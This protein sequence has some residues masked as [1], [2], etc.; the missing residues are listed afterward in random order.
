MIV[1]VGICLAVALTSLPGA[2]AVHFVLGLFMYST[3]LGAALFFCAM[4]LTA[5]F[6]ACFVSLAGPPRVKLTGFLVC[7]LAAGNL[8]NIVTFF[9]YQQR[10][11]L[12]LTLPFYHWLDGQNSFCSLLHNHT[13]K[14]ALAL[15]ADLLPG[16]GAPGG[17]DFGGVFLDHAP[18]WISVVLAFLLLAG[19]GLLM[20]GIPEVMRRYQSSGTVFLLYIIAGAMCLKTMVDGGPLTYRFAPSMLILSS[21]ALS[22]NRESLSAFWQGRG[23]A[24]SV[25]AC[26]PLMVLWVWVGGESWPS[27]IGPFM[28]LCALYTLLLLRLRPRR[29][30]FGKAATVG[31]LVYLVV[32][33]AAQYMIN[34][35]PLLL[36]VDESL[37]VT[38]VD[39]ESFTARDVTMQSMGLPVYQVYESNGNSVFKPESVFFWRQ[40]DQGIGEAAFLAQIMETHGP[41]GR[42]PAQDLLSLKPVAVRQGAFLFT[43][44]AR[45]PMP[46][47]LSASLATVLTRNNY[48]CTIHLLGNLLHASGL[49]EFV[50]VMQ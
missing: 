15:L 25:A 31:M 4:L 39:L 5:A 23:L 21:L 20:A 19:M 27:S 16:Q 41:A 49:R 11:S 47:L 14:T 26:L 22:R 48:Y 33:A 43:A 46:P 1:L 12:P 34:L 28:V 17:F 3:S 35:R 32:F 30:W 37:R 45:P 6:I 50:L 13:G 9:I 42:F 10:L 7:I 29:G 40:G 8:L 2:L 44:M 24:W 38:V 36:P 18:G